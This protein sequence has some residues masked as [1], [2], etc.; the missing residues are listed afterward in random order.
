[1]LKSITFLCLNLILNFSIFSQT[2]SYQGEIIYNANLT[3]DDNFNAINNSNISDS[4]KKIAITS[5]KKLDSILYKLNFNKNES[6]FKEENK[7]EIKKSKNFLI[8]ILVGEGIYY[9]NKKTNKIFNQK[10]SFGE[11][12]IIEIPQFKWKLSRESKKIGKYICYKATST[13]SIESRR[14][15]SIKKITAWYTPDLPIS[16]GPKDY[17]G[18]PGL[19]LE[20]NEGDLFFKATKIKLN[21]KQKNDIKEPVKGKKITLEEYSKIVKEIITKSGRN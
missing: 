19:I 17:Y 18:L 15:K 6:I 12:F 8:R 13:K 4:A 1:M 7:L 5:L 20:L 10:E 3:I 16:F 2:K 14:G 9:T 21:L 11:L